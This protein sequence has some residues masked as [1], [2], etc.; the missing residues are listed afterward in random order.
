MIDGSWNRFDRLV[1]RGVCIFFAFVFLYLAFYCLVFTYVFEEPTLAEHLLRQRDSLFL[2]FFLLMLISA[3]MTALLFLGKRLSLKTCTIVVLLALFV[4]GI[5]WVNA[6]TGRPRSD[7]ASCYL[8]GIALS[9]GQS[10][11]AEY[12]Q[13]VPH[14]IGFSFYC[15]IFVRLFGGNAYKAMQNANV[16]YFILSYAAL[17]RLTWSSLHNERVQR[18][19]LVWLLFCLPLLLYCTFVY[20]NL[21]GLACILWSFILIQKWLETKQHWLLLPISLLCALAV[22]LKPNFWISIVALTLVVLLFLLSRRAFRL[23]PLLLL[24]VLISTL[25]VNAAQSLFITRTGISIDKGA[26][27]IAWLTMGMQEGSRAAGWYNQYPWDLLD[28]HNFDYDAASQQALTDMQSRLRVFLSD[29]AYAASFYHSKLVTQWGET[30]FESLWINEHQV[31]SMEQLQGFPRQLLQGNLTQAANRYMDGFSILLYLAFALGMVCFS[32]RRGIHGEAWKNTF[33][34]LLLLVNLF[35]GWLY[36]MLFEAKSQY[37]FPYLPMMFPF[38]ALAMVQ[39][40]PGREK[41]RR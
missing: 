28:E 38:A 17:L 13:K 6:F 24:P 5:L 39:L 4:V 23:L 3:S 22:L 30:T 37:L 33:P 31:I 7:S 32:R 21:P 1:I 34:L 16:L 26:P 15:E 10:P 41:K 27:Q 18:C 25:S 12:F 14:Q 20:G 40:F 29:P 2:N 35:G 19:L 9:S 11:T 8:A 36:H